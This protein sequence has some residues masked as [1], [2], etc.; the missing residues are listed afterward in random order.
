MGLATAPKVQA[1]HRAGALLGEGPVWVARDAA[2]YWLDIHG[3]RLLAYFPADGTSRE[4][5]LPLRLTAL[6]P[7]RDGGFVGGS[8]R[9][10]V[11]L[12]EPGGEVIPLGEPEP[13]LP[14][15]R[16]NDGK[17]D[18]FGHFW[19][20]T[21]HDP[22]WERTGSLYRLDPDLSWQRVATGYMVPNGPAFSPDGQWLYHTDSSDRTIFRFPLTPHGALGRREVFAQFEGS[23]GYPDG[24]TIDA[25][26]C[27]WVAFWDGW[28]LRRF[29]PT[30]EQVGE[31][32]LPVQR[33]T[34]CA[35]GGPGLDQLF[36]TSAR[37]G[38]PADALASQPEAGSLFVCSVAVPGLP[39]PLFPL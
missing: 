9:G 7:C 2:L 34:S 13:D 27:L 24:M 19:L 5:P 6:A 12:A 35:F 32:D 1:V 31:V 28:C 20:G 37:V 26:G 36:V 4:W 14:D 11:R 29:A 30:G 22:E 38:L 10:F 3:R 8:E 16:G 15:N 39:A 23:H 21:M 17:V 25:E 18:P 33:P